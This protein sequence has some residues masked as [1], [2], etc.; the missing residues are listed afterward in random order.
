MKNASTNSVPDKTSAHVKFSASE[1]A[2]MCVIGRV[3]VGIDAAL[4]EKAVLTMSEED[5][6]LYDFSNAEGVT[7]SGHEITD[8]QYRDV[9]AGKAWMTR[10]GL[11]YYAKPKK[12]FH[13]VDVEAERERLRN[14]RKLAEIADELARM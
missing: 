6:A 13:D 3:K 10:E 11:R 2:A 8:E 7:D 4:S 5:A 1:L 12:T 9:L 14:A